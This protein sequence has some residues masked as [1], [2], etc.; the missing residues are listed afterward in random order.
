MGVAS[1]KEIL[2]SAA[3]SALIAGVIERVSPKNIEKIKR[4]FLTSKPYSTLLPL[5]RIIL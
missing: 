4:I 1:S 5:P 2:V 3:A